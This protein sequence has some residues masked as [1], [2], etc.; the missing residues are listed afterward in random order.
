[1]RGHMDDLMG[2]SVGSL[3]GI[4]NASYLGSHGITLGDL[5]WVSGPGDTK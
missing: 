2:G 4:T 3:K 5:E 1:M